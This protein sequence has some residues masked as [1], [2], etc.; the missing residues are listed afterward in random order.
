MVEGVPEVRDTFGVAACLQKAKDDGF[1]NQGCFQDYFLKGQQANQY[2]E[3]SNITETNPDSSQ[4]H[5]CMT[6]SGGAEH[7]DPAVASQFKACLEGYDNATKCD[8][9][10][11]MWSGV[12]FLIVFV[13][14]TA[15]ITARII[16]RSTNRVPVA[17]YHTLVI[18]NMDKRKE[19]AENNIANIR[20]TVLTVLE[21]IANDFDGRAL[22]VSVFSSDGDVLHQCA[23]CIMQVSAQIYLSHI[24]V[25]IAAVLVVLLLVDDLVVT[26]SEADEAGGVFEGSARVF[27][28]E[29]ERA[30][31]PHEQRERPHGAVPRADEGG[32][33]VLCEHLFS[34][35]KL[36]FN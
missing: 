12:F 17:S 19:F 31:E 33:D 36:F 3:Y 9:P 34:F 1:D 10:S 5:A 30:R 29:A 24:I 4:I 18:S 21:Q 11:I 27:D 15:N 14:F 13:L 28:E 7:P 26:H 16:G 25:H 32:A 20:G 22:S 35:L 8:I 6:F 2:F 23:D